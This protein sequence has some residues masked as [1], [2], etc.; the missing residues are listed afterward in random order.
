[1]FSLK[2][3]D[4]LIYCISYD[5]IAPNKNYDELYSAIKAF[6][7][8]WHQTGSVWFIKSNKNA[9]EIR[10]YLL[11]FIDSNDKIFVIQVA[12]NW[13]GRGFSQQ[14]YDWL[15]NNLK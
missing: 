8:W 14:E 3:M 15:H 9:G 7:I 1:M 5:L 13:G 11:Q 2:T 6:G 10:D 4:D 12:K